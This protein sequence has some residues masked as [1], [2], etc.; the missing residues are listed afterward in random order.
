MRAICF[1]R[2]GRVELREVDDPTIVAAHDAIVAVSSAGLCGSDLHVFHGRETGL[3]RGTILGHE[4]VGKVIATGSAVTRFRLGDRVCAPFSTNCGECFYCR[5]GI[6]SRCERGQLFGWVQ[7][8][9]GLHGCQAEQVR[10]PWADATLLAIPDSISDADAILLGDNLSTGFFC[11]DLAGVGT[12]QVCAVIGCGTVGLLAVIAALQRGAQ[13]VV[14]VDQVE[15]RRAAA[16]RL[17]AVA[18]EIIQARHAIDAA[19]DG[20]GADSVLEVVGLPEAQRLAYELLRPGG[21]MGV[22]GCHCTPHFAF[23]PVQAYDKNLAYRTGRCPARKYMDQLLPSLVSR[24][25]VLDSFLTHTFRFDQCQE[26]YELFA[27]RRQ[28][29]L[30]IL[31]QA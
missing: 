9:Q 6:P 21:Q 27:E 24:E 22:V 19:T 31:F 25:L 12:G 14:A 2:P 23:S 30:K 29:C 15:Y 13:T 5:N 26:A 20:R 1:D 3:D 7:G 16:S 4:F 17:G 18:V 8:G 10:V 28:N 11:A